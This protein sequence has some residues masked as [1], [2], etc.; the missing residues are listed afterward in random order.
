MGSGAGNLAIAII[1]MLF[2]L[3]PLVIIIFVLVTLQRMKDALET[4]ASE[5]KHV[6][7]A[8]ESGQTRE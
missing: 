2:S 8:I 3:I 4:I 5:L 7:I 1:P 6:R